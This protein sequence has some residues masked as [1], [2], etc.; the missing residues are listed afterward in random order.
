MPSGAGAGMAAARADS[1]FILADDLTG[2]AD[3]AIGAALA[4]LKS[5]VLLEPDDGGAQ[6]D[7]VSVD[8]DTRHRPAAEA[9]A[10]NA[11]LWRARAAPRRLF[12]KKIDSTLRGNFAAEMTALTGAGI[13]IVA[14]AYPATG[15]CTRDGRVLVGG[16]PLE[17]TETWANEGM[18]GEANLVAMLRAEGLA[19]VNLPLPVV[20]GGLRGELA[21]LVAG[22]QVQAVVCDAEND[23]DL[24]AIAAASVGLPVYWVGSAGLAAHLPGAAGMRGGAEPPEVS[25]DGPILAVIG[26]L[27]AVSRA[28][29]QRLQSRAGLAC[30][31]AAPATLR[32][33]DADARWLELRDAVG[34][35]LDAGRDLMIR[36]GAE[37]RNDLAQGR[38]LSASLGRLLGPLAGRVG[39]LLA[40][41]GE[42]ARAVLSTFGIRALR[43]VRAIE[44]GVPLSV[45]MAGRPIPVVTKAGAFG[46]PAALLR[47]YD[48]LAI[49][50]G[51]REP[52][53]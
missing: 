33:G 7:V 12:Y 43:V 16:V 41:G 19:A 3:C 50:R 29:A 13:A 10:V 34:R 21:G 47:A 35:T 39:A 11:E 48:E 40:T 36:I 14:P 1:L 30:F 2:A 27:S 52:A 20:R 8:S 15:R 23:G 32:A 25:V 28:Q 24:A 46:S 26:S 42:T 4:G 53:A 6:G 51:D 22:G 49:I 38:V 5:V 31:V 44:P 9:R 45:S 18:R 17:L 37:E